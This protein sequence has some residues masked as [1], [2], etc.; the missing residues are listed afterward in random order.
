MSHIPKKHK[1]LMIHWVLCVA[2][3]QRLWEVEA[4]AVAS[5]WLNIFIHVSELRWI[6]KNHPPVWNIDKNDG[7]HNLNTNWGV[8]FWGYDNNFDFDSQSFHC[9]KQPKFDNTSFKI[10][11]V[12]NLKWDV[13]PSFIQTHIFFASMFSGGLVW[14]RA[15]T[16]ALQGLNFFVHM[17]EVRGIGKNDPPRL[18]RARKRKDHRDVNTFQR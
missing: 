4:L 6:C 11:H 14:L 18:F 3:L 12:D 9:L 1:H 15:L 8:F 13:W 2:E 5:Q 10:R 7:K 16:E 17:L